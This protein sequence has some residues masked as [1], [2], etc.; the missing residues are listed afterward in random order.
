M[1]GTIAAIVIVVI[2]VALLILLK[3]KFF[4]LVLDLCI[5]S[6]VY[7]GMVFI[8]GWLGIRLPI[9]MAEWGYPVMLIAFIGYHV[10]SNLNSRSGSKTLGSL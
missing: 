1:A 5:A 10:I 7:F 3:K 8:I 9:S 6:L 2:V 4:T